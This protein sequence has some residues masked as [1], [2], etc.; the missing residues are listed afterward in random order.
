MRLGDLV[1]VPLA[2]QAAGADITHLAF[3]NRDVRPGTLF[4]AV[5]GFARDG[6]DFAPDAVERGA[7]A[8]IV[9]R[10]LE[11]LVP[12][13]QVDD[14]RAA[15]G[16]I[17]ARF[18]GDP[19]A[20]VAVAG[21]TGTNGKTTSCFLIRELLEAGGIQTALLG[22]VK[23]VIGGQEA[24]L[25]RTT[26][27]AIEL[28]GAFARMR[29]S[30][31]QACA[32]EVSSHALALHRV[33]AIHWAAAL[34]TN[35]TQDHLDFH[36]TME[37]Y[38][39]AKRR[40]F[41]V[42]EGVRV[43]NV[44]DPYGRRL[45]QEFPDAVTFAIDHDAHLRATDVHS[46]LTGSTFRLD[47]VALR[48]PLPGRFN[49][50]NVLGAIAVARALGVDDATIAGALPRAGRVPGRFEPVDE[51][52]GFAVVVDYSHTPD[53]LENVLRAA[54]EL[55]VP[56]AR[57]ILTFGAG[58]DRDTA[59]RPLMGRAAEAADIVI[60]TS[61]NPRSEDPEAIVAEILAGVTRDDVVAQ[62]DRRRAIAAA[63]ELARDGDVVVIAGKG[64]E[65]GQE[66][67]GGRKLPFDDVTVA[68]EALRA[69]LV[70]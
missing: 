61:D 23:S 50:S 4:F 17:A 70:A 28:Q 37:D 65:Q 24:T 57:V 53:S 46:T 15:M 63:V 22:T 67:E 55:S 41:E 40:L 39:L 38:F 54:R 7:S 44:D 43:V 47:G 66:F 69:R 42:C 21:V 5:P 27:E 52:Q 18:H 1:D 60:V 9:Q 68:R 29:T 31:D 2:P 3:D 49:V 45:A 14:A 48:T 11:L 51:G 25:E 62:L 32:M 16:P 64:H 33:D 6:H 59:K 36:P 13:V 58:G 35:L 30:G 10:P 12:Q 56:P 34:F 20:A 19:T 26:P 8:L